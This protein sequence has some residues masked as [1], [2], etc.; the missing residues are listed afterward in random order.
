MWLWPRVE[1]PP[2]FV[3]S[4]LRRFLFVRQNRVE[5][6]FWKQKIAAGDK[7][8]RLKK[9]AENLPSLSSDCGPET[10]QF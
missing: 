9:G 10:V 8:K 4:K 6:Y 5:M 1:N 3:L 2:L 7:T